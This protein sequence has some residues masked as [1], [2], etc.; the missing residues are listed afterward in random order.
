MQLLEQIGV[1]LGQWLGK[2]L[3]ELSLI[4]YID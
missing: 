2:G 1:L 3:Q 4:H